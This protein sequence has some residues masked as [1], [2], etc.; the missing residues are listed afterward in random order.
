MSLILRRDPRFIIEDSKQLSK[1]SF[2]SKKNIS[3]N[4]WHPETFIG[5]AIDVQISD[6]FAIEEFFQIMNNGVVMKH[7]KIVAKI[8]CKFNLKWYPHDAHK[9]PLVFTNFY[10]PQNF[11][12]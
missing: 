10:Y 3:K 9:C 12:K 4:L 5:N 7:S 2:T 11:T 8:Y 1:I 6:A